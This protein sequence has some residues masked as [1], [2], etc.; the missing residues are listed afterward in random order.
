MG[1]MAEIEA[2]EYL[3]EERN[4]IDYEMHMIETSFD[5]LK[6]KLDIIFKKKGY[7]NIKYDLKFENPGLNVHIRNDY[8]KIID[9]DTLK[10]IERITGKSF[11]KWDDFDED[12]GEIYGY[13]I[14]LVVE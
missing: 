11:S 13:K 1:Q 12:C 2:E 14:E 6:A 8:W 7:S 9:P 5:K 3:K 4:M 10:K